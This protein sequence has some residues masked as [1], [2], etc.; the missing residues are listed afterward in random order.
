MNRITG[1]NLRGGNYQHVCSF[2][3]FAVKRSSRLFKPAPRSCVSRSVGRASTPS[4]PQAPRYIQGS[5]PS[6]PEATLGSVPCACVLFVYELSVNRITNCA[7]EIT[8]M[9]FFFVFFF[10][11]ALAFSSRRRVPVFLDQW[12]VRRPTPPP[13]HLDISRGAPLRLPKP[14]SDQFPVSVCSC[15]LCILIVCE[16]HYERARG[17]LPTCLCFLCFSISGA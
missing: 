16:S 10:Y 5:S 15:A 13:E 17:K 8:N 6:A 4:P 7:G 2:C 14:L 1:T 12:G 3:F 9:S 11:V